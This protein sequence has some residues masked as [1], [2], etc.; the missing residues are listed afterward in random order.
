GDPAAPLAHAIQVNALTF[1]D[2]EGPRLTATWS[3]ASALVADEAVRDLAERW[4]Q[5][6]ETLVRHAAQPG[7]GGRTPSDL[8]LVPLFQAEIER[9]ELKYP[10]LEDILPLSPLQEG[11]LFHALYDVQGPDVYTTQ[12]VLGLE[13]SLDEKALE[14]AGQILLHRHASLGPCSQRA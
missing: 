7:F 1:D 9:L 12:L 3:W 6:L 2:R 11:L 14:A 8:P 5:A 13:G 10:G 4:F